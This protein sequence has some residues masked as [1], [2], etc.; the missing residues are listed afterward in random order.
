[1]DTRSTG[2]GNAVKPERFF[3]GWFVVAILFFISLIDGGFT[4]IFAAFLKPL[5][6]EFGWT[7]AQTAGGFSLYLLASG[8]VLPF[9]GWLADHYGVRPVFLLSALIDGIALLLLSQVDSL[10]TFYALYFFLGLGLGGIGPATVGKSVS[11]W[12]VEKRGQATAIALIGAGCGGLILVPLTG[13]LIE[14][15]DWRTAYQGLAAFA[16]CGMLPLVWF[17]LTN[18][19]ADRGLVPLGQGKGTPRS[20]D[21]RAEKREA[22]LSG[23][24]LQEALRTPTFWLLGVAFCLGIMAALAV[25]AHQV[26]FFQDGGLTLEAASVIAGLAVGMSMGGRYLVGWTN[27]RGRHPHT[28]LCC[29]LAMQAV[30]VGLLLFLEALGFWAAGSFILLFG[31]GYGGLVVLWP[32]TI[33]HDFGLRA[34]GAIAGVLGTMAASLGGAVGPVAVGALY[35]RT[36]NYFWAFLACGGALFLAAAAA[37]ITTEPRAVRSPLAPLEARAKT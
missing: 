9:W 4:Y 21:G 30:G 33:S 20:V 13:I 5:S 12:F 16:L 8:L 35:D 29:C 27:D 23:W 34:F 25:I 14:V 10:I 6:Q 17:F 36:G 32:L 31:L 19:P 15:S 24:T 37:W 28:L 7:R 1:M 26:A 3:Y 22:E 2:E 18:T 11:E